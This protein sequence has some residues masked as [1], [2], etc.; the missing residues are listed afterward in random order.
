MIKYS[1]KRFGSCDSVFCRFVPLFK[2]N[3]NV[4][5]PF[6]ESQNYIRYLKYKMPRK[7][8]GHAFYEFVDNYSRSLKP[9]GFVG[10]QGMSRMNTGKLWY[11][12]ASICMTRDILTGEIE[13]N[14]AA[15]KDGM[16]EACQVS[17][18]Q[19]KEF[20]IPYRL[21]NLVSKDKWYDMVMPI[22]YQYFGHSETNIHI[23][24]VS[25][26]MPDMEY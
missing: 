12:F 2:G 21:E 14:E 15:F 16:H 23:C 6:M 8:G 5:V 25:I 19:D 3:A 17:H 7:F 22:I 10:T 13:F 1:S 9:F 20:V 4:T 11:V 18:F 24:N 26:D